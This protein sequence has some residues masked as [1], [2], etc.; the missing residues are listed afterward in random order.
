MLVGSDPPLTVMMY[1]MREGASPVLNAVSLFLMIASALLALALRRPDAAK[2]AA[3][4]SSGSSR[5]LAVKRRSRASHLHC[6]PTCGAAR[7]RR[8]GG[9]MDA[10]GAI[11]P[12]R[13]QGRAGAE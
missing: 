8:G 3:G 10:R 11:P 5:A 12:A 2:A 6:R 7:L 13:H 9:I 1:A 4:D